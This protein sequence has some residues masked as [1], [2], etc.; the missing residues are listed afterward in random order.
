MST[1][2]NNY[3]NNK[4][5]GFDRISYS[6]TSWLTGLLQHF[7]SID[8]VIKADV[9]VGLIESSWDNQKGHT[10]IFPPAGPNVRDQEDHIVVVLLC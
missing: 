3:N 1:L 6:H 10:L 2:N 7:H 8:S 4:N 9:Y 5:S